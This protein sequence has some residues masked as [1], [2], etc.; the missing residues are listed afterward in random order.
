MQLDNKLHYFRVRLA[1]NPRLIDCDNFT[2]GLGNPPAT[3]IHLLSQ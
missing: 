3:N 2:L 1:S